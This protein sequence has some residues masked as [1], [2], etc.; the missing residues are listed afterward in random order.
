[1][2]QCISYCCQRADGLVT[3]HGSST[4]VNLTTPSHTQPTKSLRLS[5]AA[6]LKLRITN[7]TAKTPAT[8]IVACRNL[9]RFELHRRC[10]Q[11]HNKD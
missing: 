6:W 4:G 1:M 5:A 10:T 3:P 9:E 11:I 2:N 7:T 8:S